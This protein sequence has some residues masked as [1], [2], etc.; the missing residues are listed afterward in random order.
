MMKSQNK[1]DKHGTIS[2]RFSS[3]ESVTESRVPH[4]TLF[5]RYYAPGL[6]NKRP[7][8]TWEKISNEKVSAQRLL[9]RILITRKF[10]ISNREFK[11]S[12]SPWAFHRFP[13]PGKKLGGKGHLTPKVFLKNLWGFWTLPERAGWKIWTF[14][15]CIEINMV[16]D[17]KL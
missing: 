3:A 4:P 5:C 13:S 15:L 7:Q 12:A 17:Q 16:H 9:T 10:K 1:T 8:S 6:S 14:F 2:H 11:P